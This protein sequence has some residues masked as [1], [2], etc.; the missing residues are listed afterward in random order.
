M[1]TIT[2]PKKILKEENLII[3]PRKEYEA[4]LKFKK[5][6]DFTPTSMQKKALTKA[7]NNLRQGKTLSYNEIVRKLGFTD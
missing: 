1:S 3:I 4:L 6:K 5:V 2:I 7:E